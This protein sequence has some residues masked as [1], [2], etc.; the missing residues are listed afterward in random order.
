MAL[1][2]EQADSIDLETLAVATHF[3]IALHELGHASGKLRSNLTREPESYFPGGVY[4]TIEELR[5]D[6]FSLFNWR[7][8]IGR[9]IEGVEV[10]GEVVRTMYIK[11]ILSGALAQRAENSNAHRGAENMRLHYFIKE[12]AVEEVITESKG[13]QYKLVSFEKYHAA[14]GKMLGEV[15]DIKGHGNLTGAQ[16]FIDTYFKSTAKRRKEIM[17]RVDPLTKFGIGTV[18]PRF[19]RTSHNGTYSPQLEYTPFREQAKFTHAFTQM[20]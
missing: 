12:G 9:T 10:T 20:N 18:L 5:A 13:V 11:D 8:L 3:F 4:H 19:A 2:K 15:W 16:E 7:N 6:L 17:D 1:V 14:A